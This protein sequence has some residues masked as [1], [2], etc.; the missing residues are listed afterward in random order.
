MGTTTKYIFR[1]YAEGRADDWEA[2]CLDL[3]L[4]VQG[5]SFGDVQR[6]LNDAIA[7]YVERALELPEPDRSRLLRLDGAPLWIR[8]RYAWKVIRA[9][10]IGGHDQAIQQAFTVA[11]AA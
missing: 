8:L 7:M 10:L 11:R 2:I 4:A 9:A 6:S 5:T 3:D 1:C